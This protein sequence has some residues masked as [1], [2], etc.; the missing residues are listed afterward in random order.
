M[1]LR[2]RENVAAPSSSFP[3]PTA[4]AATH[5]VFPGKREFSQP[6]DRRRDLDPTMLAVRGLVRV[7]QEPLASHNLQPLSM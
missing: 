1:I 7:P 3:Q 4:P 6:H 5:R 2:L